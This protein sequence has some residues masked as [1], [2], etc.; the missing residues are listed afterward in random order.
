M[1]SK[2]QLKL[3][4]ILL[5]GIGSIAMS[6]SCFY[7]IWTAY[8]GL[9]KITG[10]LFSA[11]TYST[12]VSHRRGRKSQVVELVFYLTEVDK[13]FKLARNIDQSYLDEEYEDYRKSLQRADS[14]SVWIGKSNTNYES[15]IYR[16]AADERIIFSEKQVRGNNQLGAIFFLILGIGALSFFFWGYKL[17]S[18]SSTHF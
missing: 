12:T 7:D 16:I 11:D 3:L 2:R 14:V 5:I 1:Q 15:T 18:S 9:Q 8:F 10:T 17:H 6:F 13:R 4:P